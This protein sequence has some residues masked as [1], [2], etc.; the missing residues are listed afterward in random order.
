MFAQR[1]LLL[2]SLKEHVLMM[3][4]IW[5]LHI[6][7]TAIEMKKIKI[8]ICAPVVFGLEKKKSLIS[9]NNGTNKIHRNNRS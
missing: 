3:F 6:A 1:H 5:D 8:V 9:L 2:L 7:F 4:L